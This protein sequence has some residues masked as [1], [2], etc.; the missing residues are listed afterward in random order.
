MNAGFPP[1][2]GW[3]GGEPSKVG[4]YTW[5]TWARFGPPW[6]FVLGHH[7]SA[8]AFQNT[9]GLPSITIISQLNAHNRRHPSTEVTMATQATMVVSSVMQAKHLHVNRTARPLPSSFL[10]SRV[11]SGPTPPSRRGRRRLVAMAGQP[12]GDM[13]LLLPSFVPLLARLVTGMCEVLVISVDVEEDRVVGGSDRA[14]MEPD[15]ASI[16]LVGSSHRIGLFSV[17]R[18]FVNLLQNIL[19]TSTHRGVSYRLA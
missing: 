18:K 4:Y 14:T 13:A 1:G 10:T 6:C 12:L 7:W 11:S 15:C 9:K 5:S 16:C 8:G 19:L 2:R 17:F 3:K